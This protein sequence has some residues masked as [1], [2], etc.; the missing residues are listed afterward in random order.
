MVSLLE[1]ANVFEKGKAEGEKVSPEE[2]MALE[3]TEAA[4][5]TEEAKIAE[6]AKADK[7]AKAKGEPE[8]VNTIPVPIT[9]KKTLAEPQG[10]K[11]NEQAPPDTKSIP[12]VSFAMIIHSFVDQSS[13]DEPPVKKLNLFQAT[14]SEFSPTPP[15]DKS[16]GNGIA[17]EVPIKEIIPYMEEGGS[18]P[19]M[20][21]LRSFGTSDGQM[22]NEDFV[23]KMRGFTE[24]LELHDLA[25]RS[26]TKGNNL[27]FQIL[28][29]KF[30]WLK[31]QAG[32]LGLTRP[33][34]CLFDLPAPEKK[35]SR[36]SKYCKE[37]C[38]E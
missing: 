13:K 24:W 36:A 23:V 28:K 25:S 33:L 32:K 19:K 26:N 15:K 9:A 17:T 30:L 10:E 21:N 18:N 6:E 38:K 4:K 5:I 7:S 20:S 3:L 34:I 1:A 12:S 27:L 37:F 2:D 22:T 29:A 35:E 31:S 8:P 14:S 16:K 11:F